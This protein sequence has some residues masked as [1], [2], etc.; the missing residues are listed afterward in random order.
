VAHQ[1]ISQS[2]SGRR[3]AAHPESHGY[4]I[5]NP[6]LLARISHQELEDL[7]KGYG[8]TP[9]FVEGSDPESMHQAMAATLDDCVQRIRTIQSEARESGT[10]KRPRWPM[11]VLRTPKGW[12]APA[13]VDGQKL[14][15]LL[16][17]ASSTRGGCKEKS[18][19]PEAA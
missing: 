17:L 7:F 12:T 4:K 6:T 9:Y 3:C 14:E 11:I 5:N 19:A 8:Y 18:G 10:A 1:Q 2:D 13:D 16:A 15:G